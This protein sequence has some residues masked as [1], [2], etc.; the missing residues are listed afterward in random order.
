VC[1]TAIVA[2]EGEK[3]AEYAVHVS[4]K[5]YFMK[6]KSAK[7]SLLWKTTKPDLD[8]LLRGIFDGLTGVCFV[9][10]SQIVSCE[11]GKYFCDSDER[12][13]IEVRSLL[14]F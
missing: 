9:D 5:F 8:K 14:S 7:K 4:C 10:D 12:A 1:S 2:M 13:E 11:A 3:P 6:P